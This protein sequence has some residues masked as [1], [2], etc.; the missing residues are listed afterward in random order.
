MLNFGGPKK[1]YYG[2]IIQKAKWVKKF[3]GVKKSGVGKNI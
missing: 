2:D 3:S 1:D